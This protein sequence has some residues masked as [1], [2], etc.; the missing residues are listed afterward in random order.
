[1]N[2]SV[3]NT[4]HPASLRLPAT[5]TGRRTWVR[6]SE[7]A[8]W[9]RP[10]FL[11]LLAATAVLYLWGLG[12][13]GWANA[14]YS[15]AVMAATKS[16]K[17]FF[18]GSFDP[19]NFI[20]VDKPPL[21]LWV[22]DLSARL[23]GVS[24]WSILVPEA[25]EGVA[26]VGLLTAAVR[27][28]F[29]PVAGLLAGAMLA[30]TPVAVLM[31]RFNNP[32]AL[33]TLLLVAAAYATMRG[34][35]DGRTRWIV[36]AAVLIGLG[37][38]TKMLQAFL[39]VPGIALAYLIAAPRPFWTRIRQL[40][41]AAVAGLVAGGWWV[42]IVELVPASWRPYIGGSQNN[43]LLNLI[44]GYNG[45][46]RLTGQEAGSVVGRGQPGPGAWGPTGITRLFN[47]E[48]GGQI[49]W[50]L[51]A[52]LLG[53]VVL[54]V[55]S[56]RAPR[57]D[58]V[59]AMAMLWGGWLLVTGAVFSFGQG[60]IHPYYNVALAPAVAALAASGAAVLWRA[61]SHWL[62]RLTL[63]AGIGVTAWWAA[64]L[65]GRTPAWLPWLR[66]AVLWGGVVAAV[67]LL[68]ATPRLPR[69]LAVGTAAVALAVALAGPTA[70]SVVTAATP[71]TGALPSAG[72]TQ[73]AF[74][75]GPGQGNVGRFNGQANVR[76]FAGNNGQFGSG[77]NR[78]FGQFG[79]FGQADGNTFGGF[80]QPG[81]P[82]AGMGNPG[83]FGGGLGGL[84]DARTP[85]SE[86]VNLLRHDADRYTWV[87]ATVGANNAAGV[88]LATGEPIMAIGGFNG[89]DPAPTLVEFQ[90]L[91]AQGKIHYFLASG[92]FGGPGGRS[93]TAREIA[94]WVA[95]HFASTTVGGVTV[96]DLTQPL[97][98]ISN[99]TLG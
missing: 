74:R 53:L 95:E 67:G 29:G 86:L 33:L 27:R 79:R 56:W 76:G 71:H 32:D 78:A 2:T 96:Y 45:F 49:S 98:A 99:S 72:P 12:A 40:A 23:F 82:P 18:F 11:L 66:V 16:W 91:V 84:L 8:W 42:A 39:V 75:G 20:T 17:A 25:L 85:S 5:L 22:M 97:S 81:M 50:L 31:F 62:A 51:P 1:M 44:F 6:A 4:A 35:E 55:V 60:I 65:L 83:G 41:L 43:D 61:R 10:A 14:Y 93:G 89:T 13:S 48:M 57:T 59:R 68:L 38:L 15:A 36:L 58:R 19:S 54:A 28:W 70:Y 34:L 3:S 88:E 92:G 77:T 69:A 63:A 52:A 21:A 46:G 47:Q 94:T 30:L 37:F 90:Q 80:G 26:A 73:A 7:D 9:V 24:S 87:A 64:T